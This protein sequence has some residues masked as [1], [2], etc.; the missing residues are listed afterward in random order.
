MAEPADKSPWI[1]EA[2]EATF[3][4]QVV[5]RSRELLVVIDF[6]AAWCQPCRLLAPILESLARDYDGKFLLVKADTEKLPNIAGAFGVQSIPAVYALRDGQL[7]D[8]FVGLRDQHQLRAWIDRL[9][10]SQAESLVAEARTLAASKPDEAVAR[11]LQASQLDPNLASA[12]IGLASVYLAQSR[13]DEARQI[14]EELEKRGFLED[15][16]EKIKAQLHV[17]AAGN[18]TADLDSLRDKAATSPHDRAAALELAK[19][20]AAAAQF[21]EALKTALAI[22]E[23][24][25]KQF[26]EPAKNLM[27]DVFRLL[28]DDSPLTTEYRRRL[29]TALY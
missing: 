16:A 23:S 3:Q 17:A 25:D 20:L 26:S 27:L 19:A 29:S 1:V 12:R 4:Q 9:L 6:W 28:P 10:P 7:L 15:E 5:E 18:A 22:V 13:L 21:E 2:D 24:H 14:V 11:F 8:Y